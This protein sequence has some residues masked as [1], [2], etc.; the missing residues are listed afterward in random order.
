MSE[1]DSI[2]NFKRILEREL[3]KS[4]SE[5]NG[6]TLLK[7]YQSRL[8]EGISLARIVK[9]ISTLRRVSNIFGRRFEDATKDNLVELVAKIEQLPVGDF[10]KHDYRV[11]LKK[12]YQWLR[13]C[14]DGEYPP[15]VKWIRDSRK[16]QSKLTKGCLLTADEVNRLVSAATNLRDKALILT[17]M[18]SGRRIG[19]ILTLKIESVEFDDIGARL[20]VDGKTGRDFSRVIA[21]AP[22][23]TIWLDNHPMRDVPSAPLWISLGSTNRYKQLS[24]AAARS[25]L[26]DCM[27]RARLEK[28]VYFHLFRHTRATQAATRLNQMQMCSLLGWKLNSRMPSVYVHLSGEDIDEA[29]SIMNGIARTTDTN[30]EWQPKQCARCKVI[31]S[32]TSKFC[33]K[34]GAVL[35]IETAMKIDETRVKADQLLNKLTEDPQKLEKFLALIEE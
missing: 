11:I 28:R 24:Y 7:Y 26:K 31:N 17:L 30:L 33:F 34:C 10:T 1:A 5:I 13:D 12:F 32:P 19:E 35:D 27:K 23:L 3:C 22:A 14:E 8:A 9:C 2:Y 4:A 29:Q 20:L 25:A 18:E 15:E 21:S 16:P 6:N